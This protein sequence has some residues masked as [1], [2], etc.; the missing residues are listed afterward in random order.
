MYPAEG[1]SKHS[2]KNSKDELVGAEIM[3][4][5]RTA[6]HLLQTPQTP[7]PQVSDRAKIEAGNILTEFEGILENKYTEKEWVWF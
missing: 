2:L 3:Y 5:E 1:A 6:S 4:F 7:V